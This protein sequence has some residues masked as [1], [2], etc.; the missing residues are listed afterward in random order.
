MFWIWSYIISEFFINWWYCRFH[1][2]SFIHRVV[3]TGFHDIEKW[4]VGVASSGITFR[5][6]WLKNGKL[7]P[8]LKGDTIQRENDNISAFNPRLPVYRLTTDWTTG[9]RFPADTE[10]F[11]SSVS[12]QTSSG[13][14]PASYPMSTRGPFLDVNYGRGMMFADHSPSSS[15]EVKNE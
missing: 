2:T 7:D 9:V 10:G 6:D 3:G 11:S 8:K 4:Q 12:V 1:L 14:H 5:T 13:A 15:A